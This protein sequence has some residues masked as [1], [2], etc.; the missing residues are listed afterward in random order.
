M[1]VGSALIAR[2]SCGTYSPSGL[3]VNQR[4]LVN[5][6]IST[7]NSL[8]TSRLR[9]ATAGAIRCCSIGFSLRIDD[10]AAVEGSDR[11]RDRERLDQEAHADGRTAGDDGEADAGLMQ[12]AHRA[13]GG[14][15]QGLV[16]RQQ[17]AVDVGDDKR[18]AGHWGTRFS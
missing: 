15:G 16:F 7:P 5:S 10:R 1:M 2:F 12:L 8:S 14:V 4:S 18:D 11:E 6:Q 17:R 13:L 9:C 3:R